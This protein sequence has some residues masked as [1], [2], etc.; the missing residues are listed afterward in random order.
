M[1]PRRRGLHAQVLL[2]PFSQSCEVAVFLE[3]A[4]LSYELAPVEPRKGEQFELAFLSH[5]PKRL[6]AGSRA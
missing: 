6:N 3:E 1:R 4:A 5:Q 2:P